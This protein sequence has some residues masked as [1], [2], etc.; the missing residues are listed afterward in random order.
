MLEESEFYDMDSSNNYGW[1]SGTY[2]AFSPAFFS[3]FTIGFNHQYY[4][5]LSEWKVYDL[6]K[7][8]PFVDRSNPTGD[9]KDMMMS[10]PFYWVFPTVGFEVYGE[11]AR[12]DNFGGLEDLYN[13]PEHTHG[14]TLGFNQ[15]LREWSANLLQL[16]VEFT[17]LGQERTREVRAAGPWYRHGW[18]GWTQGYTYKGQLLG[19]AIGPGS[20]SQWMQVSWYHPKGRWALSVQRVAHDKDYYYSIEDEQDDVDELSEF[21]IGIDCLRFIDSFSVNVETVFIYLLNNNYEDDTH[22][23]NFHTNIGVKYAY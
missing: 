18:S 19:A 11:W 9:N 4:K 6:G 13:S 14:F 5:P 10:I 1:I 23:A 7:G 3:N 16:S 2:I 20:D 12:N 21:N 17:S 15:I 22:V 8:F